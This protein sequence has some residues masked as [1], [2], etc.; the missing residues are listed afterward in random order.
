MTKDARSLKSEEQQRVRKRAARLRRG[1][2]SLKEV[3]DLLDVHPGTVS[4]WC[5]AYEREGFD[6][7]RAKPKGPGKRLKRKVTPYREQK[8]VETLVEHLPG[9]FNLPEKL[10]TTDTV[11]GMINRK[12]RVQFPHRS[13]Y[14]YLKRWK[15]AGDSVQDLIT[16]VVF[17]ENTP[18]SDDVMREINDRGKRNNQAVFYYYNSHLMDADEVRSES[19]RLSQREEVYQY[20]GRVFKHC[21]IGPKGKLFFYLKDRPS[22]DARGIE[23]I[24]NFLLDTSEASARGLLLITLTDT[25]ETNDS[26]RK[27]QSAQEPDLEVSSISDSFKR[28]NIS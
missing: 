15:I 24:Q 26:F 1:G 23:V 14:E 4:R 12:F 5:S 25:L 7:I 28:S 18:R 21:F 8:I 27:W 13:T 16:N 3:A 6:A 17:P 20:L 10:W 2:K 22:L 11:M 9:D 19:K